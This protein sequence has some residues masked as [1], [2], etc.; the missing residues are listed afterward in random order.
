MSA[1][2]ASGCRRIYRIV[3]VTMICL[4]VSL[5][6]FFA[7]FSITA[8]NGAVK[9]ESIFWDISAGSEV[10]PGQNLRLQKLY[11]PSNAHHTCYEVTCEGLHCM[12][13][14]DGNVTIEVCYPAVVI[15]GLPKCGTSAMYILLSKFPGAITMTEKENCPFGGQS[16]WT[17]FQS[18]P[19]MSA[20]GDHS[21]VISGCL[22]VAKNL[23]IKEVL[24]HPQTHY[25]VMTR[26]YTDMLWAAY[27]FWC[28]PEYDGSTCST[29]NYWTD[30]ALHTRSPEV[31]HELVQADKN[32]TEGVV[33]PFW[34]PME[35]PCVNAKNYYS[36]VYTHLRELTLHNNSIIVIA[37][38]ELDVYPLQVAQR[39]AKAI[40]YDIEAIDLTGFT[41]VRVNT[42]VNKGA[43]SLINKAKHLPGRYNISQYLPLLPES[44]AM[45]NKCWNEDCIALSKI[46]PYYK[47]TACHPQLKTSGTLYLVHQ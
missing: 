35:K 15:T 1:T 28:K 40:N 36:G 7:D 20:V 47:Y 27:N 23:Q 19:R 41:E 4:I 32:H 39:V 18:L 42:Q 17:F 21:L 6:S 31:F 16:L 14:S 25:I 33:H 3:A 24:R 8:S 29:A 11:H 30:P 43:N 45:I 44:R 5:F 9:K 2:S 38:E 13:E 10:V 34:F 22:Q 37:S 46:P 26:D 12:G